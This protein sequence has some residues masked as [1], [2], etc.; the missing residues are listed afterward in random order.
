MAVDAG[1]IDT[2]RAI[3]NDTLKGMFTDQDVIHAV[4]QVVD[5]GDP[6]ALRDRKS[7]V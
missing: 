1:D 5:S 7:V 4:Q 6:D 2:V 3:W